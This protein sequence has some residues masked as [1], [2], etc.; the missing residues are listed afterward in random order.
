MQSV[1][2]FDVAQHGTRIHPSVE[3]I[4]WGLQGRHFASCY[5]EFM[6]SVE[7][8]DHA[9]LLEGVNSL[10]SVSGHAFDF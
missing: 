8:S 3:T 4:E 1:E 7:G 5:H 10:Q 2:G 9:R 6:Q